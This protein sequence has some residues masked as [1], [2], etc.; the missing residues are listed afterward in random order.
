[1]YHHLHLNKNNNTF[2]LEAPFKTPKVT[3]SVISTSLIFATKN[4]NRAH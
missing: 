4:K 1:M 3:V 2:N